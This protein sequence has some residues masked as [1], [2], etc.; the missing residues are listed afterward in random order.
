MRKQTTPSMT[1]IDNWAMSQKVIDWMSQNLRRDICVVELGGGTGSFRV[2]HLFDNVVTVEHDTRW[3]MRLVKQGL[4][5]L[6]CPIEGQYY[7]RDER[8]MKLIRMAD[9]VIIDGPPAQQRL[10]FYNYLKEVQN[11]AVLI[12][13]DSQRSYMKSLLRN[14]T[15]E[16]ITDGKRQTTIQRADNKDKATT[17]P[18]AKQTPT[19]RRDKEAVSHYKVASISQEVSKPQPTVQD[20]PKKRKRRRPRKANSGSS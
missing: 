5:V 14:P 20:V 11:G 10:G 1:Q 4:P 16:T 13:D 9:V 2:H 12:F 18:M 3:G 7:R 17:S 6:L 8:L 19:E 15:I